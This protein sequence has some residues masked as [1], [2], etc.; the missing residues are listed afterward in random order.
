MSRKDLTRIFE[1][2]RYSLGWWSQ[3]ASHEGGVREVHGQ[4]GLSMYER[5]SGSE[6]DGYNSSVD[7]MAARSGRFGIDIGYA[8]ERDRLL[9]ET[10]P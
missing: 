4:M 8:S 7:S 3:S 1:G 10:E 2:Q 5:G 9:G 6:G